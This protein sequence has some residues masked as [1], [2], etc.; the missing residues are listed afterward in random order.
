[1]CGEDPHSDERDNEER[2]KR[3]EENGSIAGGLNKQDPGEDVILR[4]Y[5]VVGSYNVVECIDLVAAV[6]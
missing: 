6:V 5:V 3:S 4:V 1:M 2:G